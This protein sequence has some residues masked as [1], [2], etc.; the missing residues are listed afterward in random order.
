[1]DI[2]EGLQRLRYWLIFLDQSEAD[3][4]AK[5]EKQRGDEKSQPLMTAAPLPSSRLASPPAVPLPLTAPEE[6]TPVAPTA[7]PATLAPPPTTAPEETTPAA[8]PQNEA[9]PTLA[10]T[11]STSDLAKDEEKPTLPVGEDGD[12]VSELVSEMDAIL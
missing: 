12:W 5:L 3:L 10:N 11:A 8:L 1:M 7:V 2:S 4:Q 9:G 6:T